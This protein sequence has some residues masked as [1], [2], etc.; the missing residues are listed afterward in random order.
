MRL[1]PTV[2]IFIA[3][4]GVSAAEWNKQKAAEYLD[5]RQKAWFAW[6]VA[7]ENRGG[8]CVSCHSGLTYLLARP[9]LRQAL[10]ETKPLSYETGLADAIRNRLEHEQPGKMFHASKVEP[11]A[12]QD[13]AVESV[14][15]AFSLAL[16]PDSGVALTK[17]LDRMLATQSKEGNWPWFSL[18]LSPWEAVESDFFGASL[19][20]K[21]LDLA[22]ALYRERPEVREHAAELEGYLKREFATQPLHHKLFL[23]YLSQ[24]TGKAV[25]ADLRKQAIDEA[26]AKQQP[27]GSWTIASL[28]PWKSHKNTAASTG[29]DNYATAIATLAL[30]R[31]NKDASRGVAWLRSHQDP[32]TGAWLAKSMN[33]VREP[34]SIEGHFMNEAATAYAVLALLNSEAAPPPQQLMEWQNRW[35]T[36][37]W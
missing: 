30:Q 18:G 13:R 31:A 19:A 36:A 28:G 17:A 11:R 10:H 29:G 15:S 3:L 23:L 1:C 5:A 4:A 6:P 9:A 26:I 12:T 24:G 34:D 7:T 25:P 37:S 2:A 21:A 14:V 35:F 8:A 32:A 22:P 27:D 16:D 33:K 20:A